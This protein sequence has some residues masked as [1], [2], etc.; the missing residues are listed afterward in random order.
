MH[1][2]PEILKKEKYGTKIDCWALGVVVYTIIGGCPPF[3][4]N[5]NQSIFKQILKGDY[6][7][8]DA[9]MWGHITQDCMDMIKGLLTMDQ[10]ERW[11]TQQVL[12]CAWMSDDP[13]MLRRHSLTPNLIKLREFNARSKFK[14][15]VHALKFA[16]SLPSFCEDKASEPSRD[17]IV[18]NP[19][20]GAIV[21]MDDE[22]RALAKSMEDEELRI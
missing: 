7:F 14:S 1:V 5:D 9:E 3:Y 6:D 12:D 13:A 10:K 18:H 4:A 2:G 19:S 21:G 17:S 22:L 8:D 16:K 15:V 11:S 20:Q